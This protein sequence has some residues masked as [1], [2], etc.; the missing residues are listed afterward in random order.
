MSQHRD[1]IPLTVYL[2]KGA[3][4]EADRRSAEKV[5]TTSALLRQILLG[6]EKPL[7]QR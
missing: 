3:K 4:E 7:T 6:K 2:P 1:L 5:L